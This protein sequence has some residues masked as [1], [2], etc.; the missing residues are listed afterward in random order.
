M[1]ALN[2]QKTFTPTF[3]PEGDRVD[4]AHQV[5]GNI[6]RSDHSTDPTDWTT[7]LPVAVFCYNAAVKRMIGMSPFQ[8]VY[9]RPPLLPVDMISLSKRR[10]A[11][12]G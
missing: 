2:I 6:L 7:K 10:K 8:A 12:L 1:S 4:R 11:Y 5:L 3:S 9:G